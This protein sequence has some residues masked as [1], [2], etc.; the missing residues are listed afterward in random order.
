MH[1]ALATNQTPVE[2][3]REDHNFDW[4]GSIT[5]LCAAPS[6]LAFLRATPHRR[7]QPEV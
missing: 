4:L 6:D 1:A 7:N 3:R 2:Y 5:W